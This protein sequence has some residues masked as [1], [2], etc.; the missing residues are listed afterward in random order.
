MA[1]WGEEFNK[2]TKNDY[3]EWKELKILDGVDN[4][5]HEYYLVLLKASTEF[6]NA[7]NSRL[8]IVLFFLLICSFESDSILMIGLGVIVPKMAGILFSLPAWK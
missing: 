8:S 4:S 2:L 1:Q 7:G 6:N 5:Y 3:L